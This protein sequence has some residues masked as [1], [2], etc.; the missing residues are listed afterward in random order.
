MS[1]KICF[2]LIIFC[3]GFCPAAFAVNMFSDDYQIQWGNINIGSGK[4]GQ[5]GEPYQLGITMGQIAPGLYSFENG[6][7]VKAGF[8]YIHSIIPFYFKISKLAIDFGTLSP[9]TPAI[10]GLNLIVK[11]GGAGGYQVLAFEDHPLRS[12]FGLDIPD[13][14]CDTGICDESDADPWTQT[15]KYGF[16]FN[17]SGDHIPQDFVDST[18]FRQFADQES[19]ETAKVI[20]GSEA[21]TRAATSSATFKVN[22]SPLQQAGNY[23][24]SLVF[25]AVPKY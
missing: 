20:M 14:T 12:D 15:N 22:I 13:T 23:K 3:L 18:Y 25:I 6:Y 10:D 1:K 8:Q 9:E 17:M 16:G 7:I 5:G 11:A 24:N 4:V 21:V 19:G 2:L